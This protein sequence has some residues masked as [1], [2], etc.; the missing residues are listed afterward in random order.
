MPTVSTQVTDAAGASVNQVKQ[1]SGASVRDVATLN[2]PNGPVTGTVAFYVCG[3]ANAPMN[4]DPATAKG[5]TG[6]FLG[7]SLIDPPGKATSAPFTPPSGAG[8]LGQT[9]CFLAIYTP[10]DDDTSPYY[11]GYH[12]N[13]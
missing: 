4:C 8:T 2:G 1:Y 3:P 7:T 11:P 5:P 10:R 12:T 9:Y 13:Q 6:Q